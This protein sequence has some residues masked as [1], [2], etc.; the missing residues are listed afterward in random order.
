VEKF[1]LVVEG[2][3]TSNITFPDGKEIVSAYHERND[4]IALAIATSK[5]QTSP[6]VFRAERS[7]VI[8]WFRWDYFTRIAGSGRPGL[9]KILLN[10]LKIYANSSIKQDVRINILSQRTAQERILVWLSVMAEIKESYEIDIS[11]NRKQLA[12][13]LGVSRQTL[14]EA[15]QHLKDNK[16]IAQS[17][18][19]YWL[20]HPVQR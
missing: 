18:K 6:W 16:E 10:V 19:K 17:G 12:A 20:L 7:T 3:V 8:Q 14:S 15:L 5:R 1:G 2:M 4:L 13:Y 9:L 11:M